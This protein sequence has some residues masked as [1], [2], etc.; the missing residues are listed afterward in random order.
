MSM[1]WVVAVPLSAPFLLVANVMPASRASRTWP[2]AV[3]VSAGSAEN[4][5]P[6]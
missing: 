2:V 3:A 1:A 6:S 5:L 4:G